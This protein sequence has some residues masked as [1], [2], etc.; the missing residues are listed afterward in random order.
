[1]E[2][3]PLKAKRPLAQP[4]PAKPRHPEGYT[5]MLYAS[6]DGSIVETIWNSRGGVTPFMVGSRADDEVDEACAEET[7]ELRHVMWGGDAYAPFHVPNIGD[8]IFMDMTEERARLLALQYVRRFW[9]VGDP[10]LSDL[11]EGNQNAAID[12]FVAEWT[13][14][15]CVD[16]VTVDA[17]LQRTFY[18]QRRATEARLL[19]EARSRGMRRMD[20][21][22]TEVGR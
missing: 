22:D 8:R 2:E 9:R 14:P 4:A 11:F 6:D 15:G 13:K 18:E 10:T 12:H 5:L 20:V 7:V 16:V 1:M 17:A 3:N 19:K 21:T